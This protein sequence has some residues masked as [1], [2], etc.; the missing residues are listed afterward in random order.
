MIRRDMIRV[1]CEVA[2]ELCVIIQGVSAY[3]IPAIRVDGWRL[4]GFGREQRADKQNSPLCPFNSARPIS[5]SSRRP[6]NAG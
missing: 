3:S 5:N 1:S 4:L 2:F 6:R